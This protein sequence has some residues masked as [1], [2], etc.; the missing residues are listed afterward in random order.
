MRRTS[1]LLGLLLFTLCLP[2]P[3]PAESEEQAEEGTPA[4]LNYLPLDPPLVVN[5]D[6][7][8][9]VG[10][11]QIEAQFASRTPGAKDIL[12]RHE[13]PVRH[14]LIMLVSGRP[15]AELRT[16][17]GKEALRKEARE[18]LRKVLEEETGEPVVDEVYFTSFIIQ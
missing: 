18:A 3:A 9:R 10:F 14:A 4:P 16:I 17:R 11:L 5:V 15:V 7:G 8:G 1:F 13:A 12:E 2:Q 6:D